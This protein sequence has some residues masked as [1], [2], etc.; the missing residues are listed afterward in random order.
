[1]VS[2]RFESTL[3]KPWKPV[4]KPVTRPVVAVSRAPPTVP[5]P[6]GKALVYVYDNP[7]DAAAQ[8]AMLAC[9]ESSLPPNAQVIVT[10]VPDRSFIPEEN[11]I[12]LLDVEDTSTMNKLR[13]RA[14]KAGKG[15]KL[16][17][18]VVSGL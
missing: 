9:G 1:M 4:A 6:G 13:N 17:A 11:E 5:K 10:G 18:D 2:T 14:K 8:Q 15:Y 12:E 7:K 16:L 3:F